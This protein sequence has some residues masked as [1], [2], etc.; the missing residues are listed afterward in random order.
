MTLCTRALALVSGGLDSLLAVKVLQ[1]Q[2][3]DVVGLSF[4][5]PFFNA[6]NAQKGAERLGIDLRVVDIT[7][8]IWALLK[9]PPHGFGKNM[10]PCID[11][12]AL[13]VRKAVEILTREGFD[14]IATGEVLGERPMSQNRQSLETVARDAGAEAILLRPLSARLLPET[15]PEREGKVDRSRLL[16]IEGRSRK[17]QME[18]AERYGIHQYQQPAGGCL[19]TDPAFSVR[20]RELLDHEPQ[21]SSREA[22]LLTLGRHFRLPSGAKVIIGRHAKDNERIL[23]AGEQPDVLLDTTTIPGPAALLLAS[24]TE[25][26]ITLSAEICASYADHGNRPLELTIV[27]TGKREQRTIV[28]KPRSTF[29][30]MRIS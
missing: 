28:P 6:Q 30:S 20:L 27:R 5:S 24:H 29:E 23:S 17:P 9:D 12:H 3:I 19:L 16:A 26:D 10:N 15:Q 18:L 1:E 4:E 2:G 13:M 22:R 21:A 8:E 7:E 11:C 14:L 25:S